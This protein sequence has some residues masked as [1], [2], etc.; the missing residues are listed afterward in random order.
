MGVVAPEDDV[1]LQIG[2]AKSMRSKS[3]VTQV[4]TLGSMVAQQASSSELAVGVWTAPSTAAVVAASIEETQRPRMVG[5]TEP[6]L[7]RAFVVPTGWWGGPSVTT[8]RVHEKELQ[9]VLALDASARTSY[10]IKR[11]AD[12]EH[13]WV[14]DDDGWATL[15]DYDGRVAIRMWSAEDF[16][17]ACRRG[18]WSAYRP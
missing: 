13:V 5:T 8:Q 4:P 11:V 16:A 12:W 1:E 15:A 18:A 2:A 9:S 6:S 10:F 17:D 7:T 3:K 14:L